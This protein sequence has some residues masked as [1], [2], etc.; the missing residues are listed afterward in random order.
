MVDDERR[1]E[2]DKKEMLPYFLGARVIDV[3]FLF[4]TAI[5]AVLYWLYI[6]DMQ[7]P[8]W[9]GAVYL[10]NARN[11][12]TGT[13]LYQTYRPPLIS[14]IIAG[15]WLFTGESWIYVKPLVAPFTIGSGIFLYLTLRGRKG[16]L[17]A[18]GV[19]ILTMLNAQVFFYSSQI[20]TEGLSLFFL[21]ATLYFLKSGEHNY[22]L[23]GGIMMGLCF[24]SR[25]TMILPAGV[26]FIIE[27]LIRKNWRLALA[28]IAG[29]AP[30]ILAVVWVVYMKAGTFEVALAKDV[31][32]GFV[33]SPYYI[34][35]SVEI[36]GWAILLVPVAF[37]FK[38]TYSDSYNLT[39]IT[40]LVA[41][42]LFWSSNPSNL[43]YR[44]ATGFT[45]PVN[46]LILLAIEKIQ[47]F[48]S[49][50]DLVFTPVYS[51]P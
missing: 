43:Q 39:F 17:F 22:W 41:S 23:L 3:V 16:G 46:Y 36:W 4:F 13:P 30:T 42:L 2:L 50:R 51:G 25:Y 15:V 19:T 8:M 32:I 38:L 47:Q 5:L 10:T 34:V 35:N 21:L 37:L 48:K 26:I 33:F 7:T 20:Y 49:K 31:N 14:W 27:S 45:P 28:A 12:L 1:L 9:D 44:F 40:W 6:S 11:W 29:A 24:A 18:L